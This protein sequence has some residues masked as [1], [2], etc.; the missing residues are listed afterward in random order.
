MGAEL[1]INSG[2]FPDL[3]N[4]DVAILGL[5]PNADK[6]RS[7]FYKL[8][9]HFNGIGIA[10]FGN[11][12]HNGSESNM[13]AGLSECIIAMK[14][15]GITPLIIGESSNLSEALYTG[16]SFKQTD[17]ARVSPFIGFNPD[18]LAWKLHQ[19]GR[20]F[21]TSFIG[22]QQF[23]NPPALQQTAAEIF[24]ENLRLGDLRTN[25][26]SVEPLLR[27]CDIF[28]FDL[29]AIRYPDFASAT[30]AYPSGL[31]NQ[32]ACAVCRYAGISNT[33]SLYL[34]NYFDLSQAGNSDIMQIAQMVWYILDG[35]DNRFNDQPQ[36]NN[37]NFTIYKCHAHT[38][39]DMVFL[40]SE[41][42]GRWWMQ[43]PARSK[44]KKTAPRFI[45]CS[46]ADHNAA[47]QGE[48]PERW[49]RAK[50]F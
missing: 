35:I 6:F 29:R 33:A 16:N 11:L 44:G 20:L 39:E 9:A 45:G 47:E 8:Y 14:E 23:L 48:V 46:E 27:Q 43:V 15:Y 50:F 28:E 34:L 10:D 18:D 49:Y 32:E 36:L 2:S 13:L 42:T 37:R 25:I 12:S 5:G 41:M 24:S 30:T 31:L 38:G 19:K 7:E 4:I 40:Y 1:K 21:H 22:T 17:T 3:K 26:A